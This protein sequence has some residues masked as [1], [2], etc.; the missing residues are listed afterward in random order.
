MRNDVSLGEG[1][2]KA[3]S[4][5]SISWVAVGAFVFLIAGAFDG[6]RHF[7]SGIA[8]L[9]EGDLPAACAELREADRLEP[10]RAATLLALGLALNRRKMYDEARVHLEHGLDHRPGDA[11]ILAAL[12]EAEEGSGRDDAAERHAREALARSENQARAHLVRGMILMRRAQYVEA[13]SALARAVMADP[14]SAAAHYQLSLA[15]ARLGDEAASSREREACERALG[16]VD[17]R[18]AGRSGGARRPV[19]VPGLRP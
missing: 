1:G 9:G 6:H 17:P 13:R 14:S 11:D 3:L 15:H 12:A 7:L 10:D 19:G 2:V 16:E 5:R 8:L 18:G 4:Y